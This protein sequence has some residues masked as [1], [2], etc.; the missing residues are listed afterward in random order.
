VPSTFPP[1]PISIH[2]FPRPTETAIRGLFRV[3][4]GVL[5]GHGG[6]RGCAVRFAQRK[7][8]SGGGGGGGSSC[9]GDGSVGSGASGDGSGGGGSGGGSGGEGPVGEGKVPVAEPTEEEE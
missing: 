6:V 8:F 7:V 4:G 9:G 5:P 1:L 2:S 3:R